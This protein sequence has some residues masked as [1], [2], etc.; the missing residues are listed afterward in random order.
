[1]FPV[2]MYVNSPATI[3]P[4]DVQRLAAPRSAVVQQL[5]VTHGQSVQRGDPLVTL[6]DPDLEQQ[7]TGLLGRQSVLI[8]KLS[9]GQKLLMAATSHQRDRNLQIQGEQ[10]LTEEE[11]T[12]VAQELAQLQRIRD[13][14]VIRADRS[15]NVDAWRMEERLEGRP[16]MRGDPLMQIVATDSPWMVDVMVPQNRMQNLRNAIADEKL[17]VKVALESTPANRIAARLRAIGPA[18]VERDTGQRTSSVCLEIDDARVGNL[19]RI[20]SQSS[21][22][23]AGPWATDAPANATFYCGRHPAAAVL[24]QD[25]IAAVRSSAGLYLGSHGNE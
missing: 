8:E 6:R 2:P 13:N 3:R 17:D 7:I 18:A 16:L 4:A 9:R 5:H 23:V 15:G 22:A 24:F 14:L 12:S 19:L 10:R 25:V 20:E 21:N 1:M 11:L